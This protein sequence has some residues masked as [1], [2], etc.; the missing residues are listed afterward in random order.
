VDP[1][2]ISTGCDKR[3]ILFEYDK[4]SRPFSPLV[5]NCRTHSIA[6]IAPG[7]VFT[8]TLEQ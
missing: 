4:G 5:N 6:K 7:I 1:K 8:N 2:A 3:K